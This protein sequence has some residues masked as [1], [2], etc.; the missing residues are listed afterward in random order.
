MN[1]RQVLVLMKG[2]RVGKITWEEV[3]RVSPSRELFDYLC[4]SPKWE[5]HTLD[6]RGAWITHWTYKP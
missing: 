2:V 3:L 1:I 5:S 4:E 6:N